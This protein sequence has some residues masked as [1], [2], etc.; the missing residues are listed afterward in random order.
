MTTTNHQPTDPIDLLA[1]IAD[2]GRDP[3]RGGY[4]RH[5]FTPA[6]KELR[7]W[8]RSTA[9]SLGLELDTDHNANMWALWPGIDREAKGIALGSHLDS[10]PGG[11]E[12]DG[13]LGIVSALS[14]VARLKAEGHVPTKPIYV[15][16]F[17][18]EEGGRFGIG[19]AGSQLLTGA[20]DTSRLLAAVDR[21]GVTLEEALLENGFDP[22]QA[23][24]EP[25]RLAR[26]DAYIEL[27]IEQ[28]SQLAP[29]DSPLGI[30]TTILAHG[31]WRLQI[32]GQGDHAG[33]AELSSRR[34]PALVAAAI[35]NSA[36]TRALAADPHRHAR[37]TVGRM[38]VLPGGTN[39]IAS[40]LDVWLDA[41]AELDEHAHELVDSILADARRVADQ[42]GCQL[43]VI[44][45]SFSPRVVF[46]EALG[47][48]L[49]DVI[50]PVPHIPTGAGHDA[51]MLAPH[52]P[53]TMLFVRNRDGISHSPLESAT[54]ADIR[55]GAD[56]LT[57]ILRSLA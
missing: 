11:G 49:D 10:V 31:R 29:L 53:S 39:A 45:E 5:L 16:A 57:K 41:R 36:R 9:E 2:I 56:A 47:A 15:I 19:C 27:H 30:A 46:D 55:A 14:A 40:Q 37:A 4:S 24:P 50:G 20:R 44:E 43:S 22:T 38:N 17:A 18:E 32:V 12:Y 25:E 28:G 7:E 13:P 51:G 21:D 54:N 42:E 1:E 6:E 26:L 3:I 34:D 35:I 23:G 8:F 48:Q 33:T 52:L